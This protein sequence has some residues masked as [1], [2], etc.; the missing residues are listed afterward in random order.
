MSDDVL[1]IFKDTG[2][3]MEGHFQL[4]SG[5]HSPYYWEKFRV[6][7]HPQY[8]EKL[9]KIIADHYR[10]K[11]I[12]LVA[13]PTTGGVILSYEV[14]RQL[15]IRGVFAEKEGQ[16]RVFKR[17]FNIKQGQRILVV[18][19]IL[20]TGGSIREVIDAVNE[21]KGTVIGIAVLVDRSNSDID[22]G[23]PLFSCLKASTVAYNPINCPQC[24]AGIPLTYT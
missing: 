20:T 21:L 22:F 15:G 10:D 9:C 8:T 24:A 2:S 6:L 18:D 16:K 13:G 5:L 12:E 7:Q 14:A 3:L 1:Q 19:D 4:T 17:G 11:E 23:Y